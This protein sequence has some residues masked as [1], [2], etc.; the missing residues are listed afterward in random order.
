[1]EVALV[2]FVI[3]FPGVKHR[4]MMNQSG[5]VSS[6]DSLDRRCGLPSELTTIEHK[7]LKSKMR[8]WFVNSFNN[9]RI[10]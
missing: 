3:A 4:Q 5:R 10:S 8:F 7:S 6:I 2:A 1:M 9:P